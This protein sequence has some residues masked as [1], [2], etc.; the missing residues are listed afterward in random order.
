MAKFWRWFWSLVIGVPIAVFALWAMWDNARLFFVTFL[1]GLTLAS[2]YFIVASGFTLVFGLMRNVNLAHGS[3]YL[4]GGYIGFFIA[5][6]TGWFVLAL[7]AGFLGAA[8]LGLLMQV[9]IFRFMQ[10]EDLRQTMVTIGLSIVLADLMM[11]AIGAQVHQME[12]PEWLAGPLRGIP[13]INA[14]SKYRMS[15]LPL[16]I[17]IGV[18]LWLF[19]NRTRMGMMI[20][21]GVDDRQMLA[22]SGVNVN[23]VFAV[24]FAIGAGLAGF[25]GV[26][27]AVELSMVPGED[28]RLLL[29]SLIVV[30]V[31]GMGSVVGAALGAAILGLAETYGLAYAP[32]YSV[33]FTFVIL[34]LV[35]AFRPRGLLGRPA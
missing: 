23:L 19:L 13:L 3:L 11:W 12:A 2:L 35:M 27:G 25:G 24:T 18:L 1:N 9:G 7:A 21:A 20:R 29:A 15:L 34:V 6:H 30:I 5:Q 4:L 10:G 26:I 14:Y 33:V 28:V 17:V 22:A 8:L 16:G 31:G 32:T